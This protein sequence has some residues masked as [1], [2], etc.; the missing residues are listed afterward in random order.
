MEVPRV[1]CI[2]RNYAEHAYELDNEVPEAPVIFI[3]PATCLVP[4]GRAIHFPSHGCDLQHEAEVVIRIGRKGRVH[5][6]AEALT[7]ISGLTLGLDLTLRDVQKQMKEKGLP[8]EIA[9]SFEQSAPIGEFVG[10]EDAMD[11]KEIEFTCRVNDRV[12]QHGRT[13]DMLFGCEELIIEISK[14]WALQEGDMIFTGT[15]PGVGSLQIGDRVTIESRQLGVY[16]WEVV[17]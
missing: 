7:F 3:K 9:K 14:I 6:S 16:Y 1:F 15:P 5:T 4:V 11:L 2:G 10:Y 8:W 12:R 17:A 13:R